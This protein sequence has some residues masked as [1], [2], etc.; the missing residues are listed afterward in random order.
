MGAASGSQSVRAARWSIAFVVFA[1]TFGIAAA[2]TIA[3]AVNNFQTGRDR[4]LQT[5][6]GMMD[7]TVETTRLRLERHFLPVEQVLRY[8]PQWGELSAPVTASGH[9]LRQRFMCILADMEEVSSVF[10]GRD[11]GDYYLLGA[12]R[13]RPKER[14]E[15]IG[16]P[17]G[18][19][20]IEEAILRSGRE[21]AFLVDRFLDAQGNVLKTATADGEEFDPRERPW[22]KSALAMQGVARTDVYRFVGSGSFGLSLSRRYASG[23]AGVDITLGAL[24]GLLDRMPEASDGLLA[25]ATA[26]GAIIARSGTAARTRTGE[27]LAA[28][29][30]LDTA[31]R[32]LVALD[33]SAFSGVASFDLGGRPWIAR[34]AELPLG[35]GKPE[36]LYVA[37]PVGVIVAPLVDGLRHTAL[38][39]IGL[40]ALA[41]P[42]VWL[43][44]RWISGPLA[45]LAAEAEEIRRFEL[46]RTMP[47]DSRVSE[48]LDLEL[49][50]ERMRSNLR[51]FAMYV[52]KAL[53]QRLVSRGETPEL[54]GERREITVLFLD[55]ENFTAMSERIEPEAVMERMS[56]Y[57]EA[58]T[59][60]LLA[61]G[62]TIDKFIGDAVM[63]FW[64]APDDMEG[65][66]G[67][68][69]EA[70]LDIQLAVRPLTDAWS[71]EGGQPLRTRI[72]L[73]TGPAIVG[74]VGSSDRMN[75]TA[76]GATVNLAARLESRN[77]E[78]RTAILVSAQTAAAAGPGFALAPA[79]ET[80]LKG[81]SAPVAC[82]EL[83]GRLQRPESE[84]EG[85]ESEPP[86]QA[87]ESESEL[88]P[89]GART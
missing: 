48:I 12:A 47:A 61:R 15:R 24:S 51:T 75:Y 83:T 31:I 64:N 67:A 87:V 14:L 23:V 28:A 9:P 46:A 70:A 65:H 54:G 33:P 72:G 10:I 62:A 3:V 19:V 59:K 36:R 58:V 86:L 50:M 78:L 73:H 45:R 20:Y 74:N 71:A 39:A 60:V 25:V 53:V 30:D 55:I 26:D 68:A 8:S 80:L 17:E 35:G 49:A 82:L 76:L 40:L 18:T 85:I 13:H 34:M 88:S 7:R 41:A 77:R 29:P 38:V 66:A 27:S 79:G 21:T 89:V 32:E 1:L 42:L 84:R 22:F 11:D 6:A 5:A 52:P 81:F 63:A 43:I 69:C 44:A 37:M 16:A 2:L 4:A 57:F 56:A